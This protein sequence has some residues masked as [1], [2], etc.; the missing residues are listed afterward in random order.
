MAEKNPKYAP[1]PLLTVYETAAFLKCSPKNVRRLI[2]NN[3]LS[4]VRIGRLV[5]IHPDDLERQIE[6]T[7]QSLPVLHPNLAELYRRKVSDLHTSLNNPECRTE[8]AE[9]IRGLVKSIAVRKSSDGI[10]IELFGEIIN[11]IE[12]SQTTGLK[13]KAASEETA[14]LKYYQSSVKVVAGACN[15]RY[16]HLNF[17][18]SLSRK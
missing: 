2:D 12:A 4:H 18:S 17:S 8:A 16:L 5:R 11:M 1:A 6:T 10:E 7:P 15:Q 3:D 14:S 9:I 13:E